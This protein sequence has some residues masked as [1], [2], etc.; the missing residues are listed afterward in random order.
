MTLRK[1]FAGFALTTLAA[2]IP[3]AAMADVSIYGRV[4]V[5]VD[6]LDVDRYSET[7]ISSNSS[8]IGFKG[9]RELDSLTAFFQIEQ[10][11]NISNSGTNDTFT[12]RDTFVGLSGDMGMIRLGR[13]DTPF[14]AARG[15][16]NLF[17]DQVGDMRN[18]TRVGDGRFDERTDNTVH[19]QTPKFNG[20]AANFAYSVHE[21]TTNDDDTKDKDNAF[22]TSLTYA[23]GPLDAALAYERYNEDAARG[24]RNAWRLAA[25]Y[26]VTDAVK[27]VGFYQDVNYKAGDSVTQDRNS[28]DVWGLGADFKV[29]PKTYIRGMWMTRDADLDDTK[30]NM[31]AIGVEHRLDSA[32]R[33]YANYAVVTNDDNVG[34]TP[35]GQG[36]TA[37]RAGV[38]GENAKAFSTGLRYDF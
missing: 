34:L 33:V 31:Y 13:F 22:S 38:N 24:K 18:L 32:L 8:R 5:S 17:G 7:N 23:E 2:A 11:V 30:S 29:A 16:A 3:A 9:S 37:T 12:T 27:L 36:R 19:Y 28:A 4:H 26:K 1:H 35:W 6:Y 20:L 15:P 21:G 25:G 10:E 14:K